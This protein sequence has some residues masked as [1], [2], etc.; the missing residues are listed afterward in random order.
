MEKVTISDAI[1]S[2]SAYWSQRVIAEANGQLIKV[3][4]GIGTI[5]W[6]HHDDQDELFIVYAGRMTIELR[7]QAIAL[8][9]GDLFVVPRGVEHRVRAEEEAAFVIVGT[10]ITSTAQGGKPAWS[11]AVGE[12]PGG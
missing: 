7:E 1:A 10:S 5:N 3:A 12:T 4:K 2:L 8:T 11:F 9:Q 6:H